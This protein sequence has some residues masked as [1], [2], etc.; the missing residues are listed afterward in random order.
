MSSPL[1]TLLIIDPQNDFVDPHGSLSVPGADQDAKR[2]ST[3]IEQA[4][5]HIHSISLS[6]DSHQRY[7]ISHPLWFFDEHGKPPDPFTI[8]TETD[9]TEGRWYTHPDV[10]SHTQH[11]LKTLSQ[12]GRYPH[13]IWPEHCLT[14]SIGHAIYPSI[15][16]ALHQ[17]SS[18]PSRVDYVYKGQNPLT[19]HFSVIEAEVPDPFDANTQVNRTLLDRLSQSNEVWVSGW[20]RSH[21]V[22][23]TLRDLF[24]WGGQSLAQ[25]IVIITDTMSDV[26]GFESHG[27]VVIKES[28]DLGARLADVDQLIATT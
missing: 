17:W 2:L 4:G 12:K 20:A 11:Y 22:G 27:E 1:I 7:D 25:K 6:L 9:L 16:E 23:N 5:H 24:K 3:L 13:V 19:E 14:G 26:P 10:S 28:L 18:K 8:I 15:Q 21:C